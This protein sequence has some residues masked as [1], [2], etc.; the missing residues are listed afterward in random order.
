MKRFL[1]GLLILAAMPAAARQVEY[2]EADVLSVVPVVQEVRVVTPE[3]NCWEERR[4]GAFADGHGDHAVG[5]VVGGVV[6]GALG[7]GLGHKKRNKQVGAVVGSILGA[8]LG[9]AIS[10]DRQ[11]RRASG[12]VERCEVVETRRDETRVVGYDVEYEYAGAIHRTRLN[13]DPGATLRLRVEMQ[14]VG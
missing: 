11:S 2:I 12:W 3:R 4:S 7:P 5:L 14:P 9:N 1:S 13:R 6:G 10:H 8:T